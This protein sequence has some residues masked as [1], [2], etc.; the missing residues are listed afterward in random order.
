MRHEEMLKVENSPAGEVQTVY[1]FPTFVETQHQQ[2]GEITEQ[3]QEL[4]RIVS[5]CLPPAVPPVAVTDG[6]FNANQDVNLSAANAQDETVLKVKDADQQFDAA[7]FL[8][9]LHSCFANCNGAPA[10]AWTDAKAVDASVAGNARNT[11]QCNE[12]S[13]WDG[14]ETANVVGTICERSEDINADLFGTQNENKSMLAD[15]QS[16]A[17]SLNQNPCGAALAAPLAISCGVAGAQAGG[18]NPQRMS[19]IGMDIFIPSSMKADQ[20]SLF[21][22]HSGSA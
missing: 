2:D 17:Y 10:E 14:P 22:Y 16:N 6:G 8:E 5:P 19:P 7:R 11:M 21:P 9:D 1:P 4:S 12:P 3:G 20:Q 13:V 18:E 15:N